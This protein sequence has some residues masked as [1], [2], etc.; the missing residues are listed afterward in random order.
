[1]SLV[2]SGNVGG[3][4]APGPQLWMDR[5]LRPRSHC[6]TSDRQACFYRSVG[7]V[8]VIQCMGVASCLV[9]GI[10]RLVRT[11][12]RKRVQYVEC[13]KV[14]STST[15]MGANSDSGLKEVDALQSEIAKL[16]EEARVIEM[17][18]A[19][20]KEQKWRAIFGSSDFDASGGLSKEELRDC[21][22]LHFSINL[23]DQSEALIFEAFDNN[24]S[25]EL[26]VDEFNGE[27]IV[28]ALESWQRQQQ[29]EQL[30]EQRG[31]AQTVAA[32]TEVTQASAGSSKMWKDVLGEGNQDDGILVRV[33]CVLAYVLPLC[34]GIWFATPLLLIL[35]QLL[36][37]ALPFM[38]IHLLAESIPFGAL[39]WFL[40]LNHLSRQPWV[41]SLLR[42]HLS[43]AVRL[44]FRI[45]L[46]SLFLEFAPKVVGFFVPLNEDSIS[47]G[48][49]TEV[50]TLFSVV[51]WN[52]SLVFGVLAFMVL[53]V[54]LLYTVLCSLAGFVPERVPLLARETAGFLGL[55]RLSSNSEAN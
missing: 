26:E 41:P 19:L 39:I 46:F 23:D 54:T 13:R 43:Q 35:P 51:L 20:A 6:P 12:K 55:H 1:M 27:A 50:P 8:S 53:A 29:Q 48:L 28:H 38:T 3:S 33:G 15:A 42:F 14:Q 16:R 36:Q 47:Q 31:K 52:A 24:K 9:S 45:S 49:I 11:P 34:S 32:A 10:S 7:S 22:K 18:Q 25:G 17:A 4:M 30:Q 5:S 2:A 37:V 44:D 40:L 21:M